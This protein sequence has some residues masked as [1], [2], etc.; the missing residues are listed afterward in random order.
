MK[1]PLLV[2]VLLLTLGCGARRQVRHGDA[3]LAAGKT[4]VAL[5]AYRSALERRPEDGRALLGLA[6]ALLADGD[7]DAAVAPARAA[8]AAEVRGADLV[9][10]RAL[11][12]VGQGAEARALA[13]AAAA[14]APKDPAAQALVVEA[15]LAS[16]DL[17][18]ARAAAERLEQLD[19]GAPE[20]ALAAWVRARSGDLKGA[21]D[22]ASKA[23]A[24]GLD[25]SRVQS[26][27]AAVLLLCG[28]QAGARAAAKAAVARGASAGAWAREASRRDQG[29]DRE[30][31]IRLLS[32]AVALDPDDGRMAATLGQLYLARGADERAAALLERAVSLHPYRDP[33]VSGV[34]VA[35]PDDWPEAVRR[36]KAA[37]VLRALA[38][39]R[40][41]I[42]DARGAAGALQQA[43]ELS[44]GSAADWLAVA[45]AWER[46]KVTDATL[47]ALQRAIS[48]DAANL[49]ARLRLAR[50]LAAAGQLGAAIAQARVA[51]E[52]NPRDVEAALL[53]G[54]LYEQRGERAQAR[55]LYETVLRY[56]PGES[57]LREALT[58]LGG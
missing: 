45:D 41:N 44:Q 23:A 51:W 2:L 6:K 46:A 15:T 53:L 47:E 26:E 56:N 43:V 4:S 34:T 24:T 42:G 39:A 49:G 58:R 38:I 52:R 37:E 30:G 31:A 12:E 1:R 29:G 9:L 22:L 19:P 27:A 32:W 36:Q 21:A 16:G 3:A 7:P 13:E 50:G 48:A 5:H 17:K 55:D 25:D 57:R 14:Q 28:E 20:R 11:V 40:G 10:A 18:A 8:H 33:K 35:R 54:S